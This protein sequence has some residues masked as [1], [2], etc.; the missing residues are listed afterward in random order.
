MRGVV[1]KKINLVHEDDR[2]KLMEITN[3]EITGKSIKIIEVKEE[4][5]L[6]GKTG[7][8]HL[9]P[10]A[11]YVMKGKVTDYT[12][13]NVFTGEK[14]TTDLEEGDVVLRTAG[15]IHGGTFS[16]G[17]IIMDI[18][19]ENYISGDFNDIPREETK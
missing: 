7:H 15:I 18:A 12:M 1:I 5:Y 4:S 6:G 10:E 3:G 8:W 11:M 14:M 2:R 16:A 9:Y 19:G 17:A 13:E